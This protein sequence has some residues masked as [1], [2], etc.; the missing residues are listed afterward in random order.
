MSQEK[1]QPSLRSSADYYLAKPKSGKGKPVLVLHAWWGLNEFVKEFCD[2]LAHEGFIALA[3][4]LFHGAVASTIEQAQ[5]HIAALEQDAAA[6]A[7]LVQEITQAAEHLQTISGTRGIGVVGISFGGYWSLWLA[8]QESSPVDAAVVFY[9]S[10]NGDF[11]P[12]HCAFQFH[13]AETDDYEPRSEVEKTQNRLRAAGKSAEFYSYAGTTHWFFESD[14]KDAYDAD[15]AKLAWNRTVEFL[16]A[17][18]KET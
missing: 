18:L 4:D 16:K 6:Q 8:A 7:F 10:R 3:P 14:R 15:A 9:A 2:R 1:S 17:H 5:T 11:A 12:S 13:I